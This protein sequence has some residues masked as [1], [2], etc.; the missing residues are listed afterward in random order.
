MFNTSHRSQHKR[1]LH[2]YATPPAIFLD[3]R[4]D[5]GVDFLKYREINENIK[6]HKNRI[7]PEPD[8]IKINQ[9][10]VIFVVKLGLRLRRSE[11]ME[12]LPSELQTTSGFSS[13]FSPSIW[14]G[15]L[16]YTLAMIE[17][18]LGRHHLLPIHSFIHLIGWAGF[19]KFV[20]I[21]SSIIPIQ[22]NQSINNQARK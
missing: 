10:T 6:Y 15:I 21:H 16:S 11:S 13:C 12:C 3:T 8:L 7:R 18:D 17:F 2:R 1:F 22:S 20:S 14:A 4:F 9:M 5:S 19:F